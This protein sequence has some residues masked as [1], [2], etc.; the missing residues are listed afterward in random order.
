MTD[1]VVVLGPPLAGAGAVATALRAHLAGCVVVEPAGLPPGRLPDAVVFVVSAAAP[2]GA[3][4]VALFEAAAGRTDAVVAAVSKI[5]MHRPWRT[6]LDT[7]RAALAHRRVP[8]VGVAADPE[9]GPQI[10]G[11]LVTAVRAELDGEQ[12]QRRNR[13]RD[14]EWVLQRR[15]AERRQTAAR[16]ARRDA[17]RAGA[18]RAR[19]R[20]LST[21]RSQAAE[22]RAQ[23]RRDAA[24]SSG[25]GLSSVEPRVRRRARQLTAEFDETVCRRLASVVTAAGGTPPAFPPAVPGRLPELRP[26]TQEDRLAAV[27]GT[28]FG[29]GVALT[30]GRLL[31]EAMPG[32]GAAIAA[33]CGTA[34]VALAGW[35]VRTRRLLTARAA[36]D[37]WGAEVAAA[38][39]A[40]WEER[41]LTAEAAALA[42]APNHAPPDGP[43]VERYRAE[44]ARV[45]AELDEIRRPESSMRAGGAER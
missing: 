39:R 24:S 17:V 35:V 43:A 12:R 25:R 6:V 34:G 3:S 1:I 19:T 4:E 22:L 11:P 15:I 13:L 37:R 28:G 8:W 7:N 18:A 16:A 10:L 14:G 26:A 45:R 44:L 9:I 36:L 31:T 32:A 41:V 33:V 40:E 42:S 23:V 5:D 2:M 21:A 20:L 30:L 27:F 29:L 38:V